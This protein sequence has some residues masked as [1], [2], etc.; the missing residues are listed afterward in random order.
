MEQKSEKTEPKTARPR[1]KRAQRSY[2]QHPAKVKCEAVLS[3]WT[4]RRKP[5]GVCRELGINWA[6]LSQ[7]QGK[8]IEGM[9]QAL[10]PKR[11]GEPGQ[12]EP[13]NPKLQQLL[14]RKVSQRQKLSKLEKRLTSILTEKQQEKEEPGG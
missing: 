14:D 9:I 8:A 13:L 6:V 5:A 12:A 4:Q 7:W 10:E 3:V 2:H 1:K 11:N